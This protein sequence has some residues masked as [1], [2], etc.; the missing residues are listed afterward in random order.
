MGQQLINKNFG[1]Q[2]KNEE[3]FK[4]D[5]TFYRLL[6]DDDTMALNRGEVSDCEPL[7]GKA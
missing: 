5:D 3:T 6:E 2:V 4:D 1:L 7:P